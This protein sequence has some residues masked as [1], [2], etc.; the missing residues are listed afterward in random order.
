LNLIGRYIFREVFLSTVIVMAVL[1]VIFMSNQFAE[2]L[3]DA[4]ADAV[5]K[6]AIFHVLGLQLIRY[7]ALLAPIGI[8][9]GILLALARFNRDSEMAAMASCGVGPGTL[10]K[11]IG[12]LSLVLAGTVGWLSLVAGPSANRTIQ[13][14]QFQARTNVELG[15][16]EPGRFMTVDGGATV[17]YASDVDGDQLHGVFIQTESDGRIVVVVAE[18]GERVADDDEAGI[19]LVLRR[20]RRYEGVPGEARY[21]IAEFGT[22]GMPIEL[23][24]EEFTEAIES[25]STR[26]L[27]GD[28]DPLARAEL[29]WRFE[30][31]ISILILSLLA[32]SLGRSSPREG[33]YARLGI[34]LLIYII[35]GNSSL[36][37]RVWV[38]HEV[39]PAWLGSW[40]V[41]A[42]LASVAVIAVLRQ[43]GV[44]MRQGHSVPVRYEPTG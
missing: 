42:L 36:I 18:E 4:A 44:G 27:I 41:H 3:G 16:F 37:A 1:L 2:T 28:A 9:L 12:L 25:T 35:Y 7:S 39:V 17:I 23:D 14:I 31:P 11:P 30:T 21:H 13:E 33:R 20:G 40:W 29:E 15:V 43:S 10:L 32:V 19:S 34:G 8:L 6:D 5:P 38:E 24:E 22:Q 26:D